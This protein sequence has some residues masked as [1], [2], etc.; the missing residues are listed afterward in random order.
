VSEKKSWLTGMPKRG[1]SQ[2]KD[3]ACAQLRA[4][5]AQF[6]DQGHDHS[7]N[8]FLTEWDALLA[9][10]D[11]SASLAQPPHSNRFSSPIAAAHNDFDQSLVFD[12]H[13]TDFIIS[14]KGFTGLGLSVYFPRDT[15][16]RFTNQDVLANTVQ[17]FPDSNLPVSMPNFDGAYHDQPTWARLHHDAET[18]QAFNPNSSMY[19]S[20]VDF[21]LTGNDWDSGNF[22]ELIGFDASST[23]N[24]VP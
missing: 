2:P 1:Q 13:T 20:A 12:D 22:N 10:F 23:Q 4:L 18:L 15:G 9:R 19:N 8:L 17:G 5:R 7:L 16:L 24:L 11:H 6:S 14:E 3:V 21:G